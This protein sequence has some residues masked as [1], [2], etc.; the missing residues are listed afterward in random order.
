MPLSP[1]AHVD[2]FCRDNLPPAG[3]WP[4]LVFD[5]PE[6]SYPARLNAATRLLDGAVA[7][8]GAERRAVLSADTA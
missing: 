6:L 4:E 2:T 1:S 7:R 8:W 5:R 3:Q